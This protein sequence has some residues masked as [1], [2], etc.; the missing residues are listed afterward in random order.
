MKFVYASSVVSE[1]YFS[2]FFKNGNVIPGQQIQKYHRL[3]MDGLVSN[4]Q[5][6]ET[7]TSIPINRSITSKLLFMPMK[8][9][10]KKINYNYLFVLNI[11]I[12]K[13]V[14]VFFASFFKSLSILLGSKD[15]V[16]ICDVLN[17]TVSSGA[18]LASKLSRKKSIGII[19]DIPG[20]LLPKNKSHIIKINDYVISKYDSY[21]LLTSQMNDLV[22]IDAKPFVIIEGQVDMDM[23]EVPNSISDKYEKKI[24]IYAGAVHK[25]YGLEE[26]VKGF[27]HAN[28]NDAELHI[29]GNGDFEKELIEVSKK[30]KSVKFFGVVPNN[31]V[32]SEEIKA[33]LLINPRPSNNEFTKYSF[34]SKNM[35]YMVSGTPVLTTDLPGMPSEYRKYV[36]L[37]GNESVEGISAAL[38]TVL[39]LSRSE[40]HEK[41]RL[42]KDF[43]LTRK[44]NNIQAGKVI[45]LAKTIISI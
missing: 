2:S 45:D 34:P 30:Y 13:N 28:I 36:Y 3:I 4:G 17:L 1:D 10:K 26:L 32:V 11:P 5:Y 18:L 24:C 6:I 33:T 15:S 20:F 39:S 12:L 19:T 44:N 22:N 38:T 25:I 41:G 7:I 8:E 14:G 27:I 40:L 31:E 21:V 43:V 42:A 35:E 29:Y 37:I 9:T 16:L 23:Q